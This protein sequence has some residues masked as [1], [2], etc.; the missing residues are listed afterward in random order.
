[1]MRIAVIGSGIS[2]L[3][4]AHYLSLR[5]EVHVF[6]KANRLGGHT[7]TVT[8]DSENGPLP[9]DTGFIVHNERT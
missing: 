5:H 8:V 6:E 4:A 1:M 7:H 2:G 9:I 3:S